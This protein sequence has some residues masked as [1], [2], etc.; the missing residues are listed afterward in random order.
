MDA[1]APDWLNPGRNRPTF[2]GCTADREF[3]AQTRD[4]PALKVEGDYP[5]FPGGKQARNGWKLVPVLGNALVTR[6][7]GLDKGRNRAYGTVNG[8]RTE[9]APRNWPTV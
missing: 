4:H 7:Q 6:V 3:P 2:A 8:P 5:F 1:P 9:I